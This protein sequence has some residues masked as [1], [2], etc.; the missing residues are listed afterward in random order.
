MASD[1]H[2]VDRIGPRGWARPSEGYRDRRWQ[3]VEKVLFLSGSTRGDTLEQ[4]GRSLGQDF[5]LFDLG[6]EEVSL[7]EGAGL[8]DALRRVDFYQVKL[9]YSFVAMGM[10]LPLRQADGSEFDFW[11]ELGIPFLTI[12]GDSPAYFFDRHVV[13]DTKFISL[14]GFAEHCALR[15][16]LPHLHGPIGTF[17]PGVLNEI[18][19]EQVDFRKK[20]EGTLLF[21]KNGKDPARLKQFWA[22]CLEP[23]LLAAICDL[24]AELERDLNDPA[25]LQ[26]DDLITRYFE[27]AGFDIER[28]FKLRLFFI[29]QLDDYL[30]AVKSTRM[31]EA[32]M[33]FPVEIRGNNWGHLDFSGKRAIYID[34]CDYRKSMTLIRESLGLV[35]VSPNTVSRPHD[36]FLRACGAH[37][38]CL[39]NEQEFLQHLPHSTHLSF[40]FDKEEFQQK[41]AYLLEHKDAALA[42]GVEAAAAYQGLH[43]RTEH[44]AKMLEYASLSRLDNLRQRPSGSQDFFVWPPTRLATQPAPAPAGKPAVH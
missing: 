41:V 28:L 44:V 34:E 5:R 1:V 31:A 37:T 12:H 19:I 4:I 15:K 24:A 40:R 9:I 42:M 27:N 32:L 11:R 7:R 3:G 10:D 8:V 13:K 38:L 43:P 6:Y 29:A 14:Y 30:R 23:R 36:R 39:T 22:S 33:D 16:R 18:P 35:D 17:W 2:R 26:V 25:C 20:K 21:L